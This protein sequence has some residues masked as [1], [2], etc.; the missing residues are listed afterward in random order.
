ME[1]ALDD[2][3][4]LASSENRI[5]VLKALA[6]DAVTRRQLQD[7]SGVPRSSVAR[8][9]DETE[10]R[11]WVA[12]SGSR[13]WITERG[14]G[15]LSTI[16]RTVESTQG[17]RHLGSALEWLPDPVTSLDYRH[18]RTARVT[19]PTEANPTASLDRGLELIRS[20]DVYRGLTRN[21]L[22]SYMETVAGLVERGALDFE[23]VLQSDFVDVLREDRERARFWRPVADRTWLYEGRV[24]VNMHIVDERVAIW[25]CDEDR[26][27]G[28]V[29][30]KGLLETDAARVV[31]WAE[32]YYE[33]HRR[34]AAPMRTEA[35]TASG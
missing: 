26:D 31:S 23:A 2:V 21:S 19:T 22:P 17:I 5:R 29:E 14:E 9:L 12:S 3:R 20:A 10:A 13:Y 35:L 27:D 34:D 11:D 16:E 18:L 4:F 8:V 7:E 6:G 28:G 32:S 24:P 15:M 25:L 1:D 33:E 30:M